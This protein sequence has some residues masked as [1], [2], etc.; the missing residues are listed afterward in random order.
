MAFFIEKARNFG[1]APLPDQGHAAR[2]L[3]NMIVVIRPHTPP[4]QVE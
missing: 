4:A 1:A 2:F 3:P